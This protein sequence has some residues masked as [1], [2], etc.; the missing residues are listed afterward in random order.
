[1]RAARRFLVAVV[2]VACP[3]F[4]SG[5]AEVR[6]LLAE[7]TFG[8]AER[9]ARAW[10]AAVESQ[11]G[12]TPAELA[13]A[14]DLAAEAVWRNWAIAPDS[15]ALAE[16]AL[17][18]RE[19]VSREDDA[20][21]ATSLTNLARVARRLDDFTRARAL[22]ER[23]LAIRETA[24]GPDHPAIAETLGYLANNLQ[25]HLDETEVAARLFAR[26]RAIVDERP[27]RDARFASVLRFLGD[28]AHRGSRYE[29]AIALFRR[30]LAIPAA[31]L[32][33]LHADRGLC[34]NNLGNALWLTGNVK[35][36]TAAYRESV[37]IWEH[38]YGRD[39]PATALAAAN[40]ARGLLAGEG[41]LP[42][43]LALQR[44]AA[45][46]LER[47]YGLNSELLADH[48]GVLGGTLQLSGDL[49]GALDAY[50][51]VLA[52]EEKTAR[53]GSDR[54][55]K[56]RLTLA[57]TWQRLGDLDRAR[58]LLDQCREFYESKYGPDHRWVWYARLDLADVELDRGDFV[59]AKKGLEAVIESAPRAGIGPEQSDMANPL[60]GLG[61]ATWGLEGDAPKAIALLQR[62][63]AIRERAL[64]PVNLAVADSYASLGLILRES[65]RLD[66]ARSAYERAASIYKTMNAGSVP[67]T[68]SATVALAKVLAAQ[69]DSRRGL[70]LALEAEG[71]SREHFR[72]V[73]RGLSEDQALR[74]AE[75]RPSGLDLALA[76]RA[77]HRELADRDEEIF[78]EVIRSRA[79]V[80]DEMAERRR[81]SRLA[82]DVARAAY[83][84]ATARL[85]SLMV[86]G[87]GAL[88][89]ERYREILKQVRETRSSAERT[90]AERSVAFRRRIASDAA[91]VR[92]V[93]GALRPGAAL[94]SFVRF[95]R[96]ASG[97]AYAA[98]VARRGAPAVFLDLGDARSIDDR[99]ARWKTE[100]SRRPE[101]GDE[102]RAWTTYVEAGKALREAMWD[103]LVP[104]LGGVT[105]LTVVPDG[106]LHLVN[107]VT[108]PGADGTFLVE[109]RQLVSLA[110]AERDLLHGSGPSTGAGLLAI[111]GAD[112][113]RGSTAEAPAALRGAP[114][115]CDGFRK[116]RFKPLPASVKEI[117]SVVR[118]W[119]TAG[120]ALRLVD[121]EATESA[122]KRYAPGRRA[123]HLATHGVFLGPDCRLAP[124][125]PEGTRGVGQLVGDSVP[126]SVVVAPVLTTGEN[127]RMRPENPL[128]LSAL[129]FAGANRHAEADPGADDG[130]LTAEEIA[131][132]DLS[133]VDWAVLSACDTGVGDIRA[134]EGVFGLRRAFRIAGV[135]T[136]VSSLWAVEDRAATEWMD[137]VYRARAGSGSPAAAL[138]AA[139]VETIRKLRSEGLP[140]HPFAWGA[141]I[142]STSNR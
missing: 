115:D 2:L 78:D 72:V 71:A 86:A 134:G 26:A 124:H 7:G 116:M 12:V 31:V 1:V 88:T 77:G 96:A 84:D 63:L 141:F 99:V 60:D 41:D 114:T 136:L 45:A 57:L 95:N 131:T 52:I 58:D 16:R 112:F 105:E 120:A 33:E 8:E 21:L 82:P 22:D 90:L 107:L 106:L 56:T 102:A 125:A 61:K 13:D 73:A 132:L 30:C 129:V 87:P 128:R 91:G 133:T 139:S 122:F 14:L 83:D 39:H 135:R 85:A 130:I 108:L 140:P 117:D 65:G 59:A 74:Y 51:R 111:G 138:R 93:R 24:L 17:A 28:E 55:A 76:I 75:R 5:D 19:R 118:S 121:S 49:L 27:S 10:L 70:A 80:L 142:A 69:G 100:A 15:L 29:D 66:D 89:A 62:A 34:T 36:A 67:A 44:R 68:V 79:L 20:T 103:P 81:A 9:A 64:G 3:A 109:S 40:V 32:P 98:F 137:A 47:A 4:A 50:E 11:P 119:G 97:P 23:A 43:A 48:L 113:D 54:A 104:M 110:S 25:I 101:A 18:S 126:G 35:E 53:G 37:R 94:V 92:E 6:R 127:M 38:A 123:L 42:G 46:I